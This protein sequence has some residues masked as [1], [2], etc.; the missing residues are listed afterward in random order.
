MD[1][2]WARGDQPRHF[3]LTLKEKTF[4]CLASSLVVV[5][6]CETFDT[7]YAHVIEEFSKR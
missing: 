1:W 7:A 5:R 6:F 3:V 4:E 2:S